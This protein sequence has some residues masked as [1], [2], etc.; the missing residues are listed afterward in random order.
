MNPD[1]PRRCGSSPYGRQFRVAGT[2]GQL[3]IV[4][5]VPFDVIRF[6]GVASCRMGEWRM[7]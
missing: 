3:P 1:E 2:I 4:I 7:R 5:C 6:I